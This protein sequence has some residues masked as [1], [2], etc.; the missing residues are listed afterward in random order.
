MLT[1]PTV[2]LKD[3]FRQG[4][5]LTRSW[6][7]LRFPPSLIADDGI[8]STSDQGALCQGGGDESAD[9]GSRRSQRPRPPRTIT[10]GGWA[11]HS[12]LSSNSMPGFNAVLGEELQ[13]NMW[14]CGRTFGTAAHPF[15]A[16]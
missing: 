13:I 5:D 16:P 7:L 11:I 2:L 6:A 10:S 9:G 14:A 8:A 3:D 4:L 12:N 1:T 15:E